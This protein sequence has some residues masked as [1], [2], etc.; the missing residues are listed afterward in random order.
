MVAAG[1]L[2]NVRHVELEAGMKCSAG[3]WKFRSGAKGKGQ[4]ER[5]GMKIFS[6]SKPR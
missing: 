6:A 1:E 5:Y 2:C 4:N 3:C